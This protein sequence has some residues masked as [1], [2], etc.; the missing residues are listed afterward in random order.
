MPENVV[1][2]SGNG[3]IHHRRSIINLFES[4]EG[5]TNFLKNFPTVVLYRVSQRSDK[6]VA[7]FLDELGQRSQCSAEVVN[8]TF[9]GKQMPDLY[10]ASRLTRQ[11]GIRDLRT[12]LEDVIHR[13]SAMA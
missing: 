7:K 4:P 12:M 13:H 2:T 8:T 10:Q 11:L 5:R 3:T 9:A 1:R 6:N